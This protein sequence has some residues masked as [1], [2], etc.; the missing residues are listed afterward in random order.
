MTAMDLNEFLYTGNQTY[1]AEMFERFLDDP[2]AVD[3]D[4]Q[5]FFAS[6]DGEMRELVQ[7]KQGAS[8]APSDTNIVGLGSLETL[9]EQMAPGTVASG[10][11]QAMPAAGPRMGAKRIKE[12][13][14]DSLRALMLI[15]SYR[16]RGHLLAK[17]DPLQLDVREDHPELNPAT[18]GFQDADMDREI[19]IN[20]VLG[21]ESATIRE[22]MAILHETYCGHIG[23]EYMHI[24]DPDEKAWLQE[25]MESIHNQ[26]HFTA[27]GK[28][29]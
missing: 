10:P 27:K 6:L 24:Q 8:W 17:I 5:N 7:E 9:S 28:R 29:A 23:I 18:Y 1:I 22:I 21:L 14:L 11:A 20:Y 25:R 15:R 12:A 19:F 26:T 2:G 3:P 4:W 13:T 16:V